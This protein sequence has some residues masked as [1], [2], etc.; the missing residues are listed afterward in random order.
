LRDENGNTNPVSAKAGSQIDVVDSSHQVRGRLC[1]SLSH[2]L[3]RDRNDKFE[4]HQ[5]DFQKFE[6]LRKMPRKWQCFS[7]KGFILTATIF[8]T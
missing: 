6:K 4:G 7:P 1:W 3:I 2:T 8:L 5:P